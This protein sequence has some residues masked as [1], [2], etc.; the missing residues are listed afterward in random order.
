MQ[1]LLLLLFLAGSVVA[2][3]LPTSAPVFELPLLENIV[4]DGDGRDWADRGLAVDVLPSP[5]G[6]LAP[7]GDHN[8][9]LR[10]GWNDE[11][12]LLFAS[13]RDDAWVEH[14]D[15]NWLWRYDGIEVFLAS[16]PGS[17]N[18]CQWVI[19]PGMTP[20]QPNVRWK[21]HDHRKD[22]KARRQPAGL[23]L[24]R[25]KS[26]EGYG[27]E[28]LVPWK[29]LGIRP[30]LN[31]EAGLQI[32]VNDADEVDG[33]TAHA[34]WFPADNTVFETRNMH[35]IRLAS[36]AGPG[37][38]LLGHG[39]Y[40]WKQGEGRIVAT[41]SDRHTG[42]RVEVTRDDRVVASGRLKK[43]AGR[44]SAVFRVPVPFS[45]EWRERLRV[46][47]DGAVDAIPLREEEERMTNDV[48]KVTDG[49]LFASMELDRPGLGKVRAAVE[50]NDY[51]AAYREWGSY[52]ARRTSP[53]WYI[54]NESY[55]PGMKKKLPAISKIILEGCVPALE[56]RVAVGGVE[57]CYKDGTPDF[58][59]NPK[60]STNLITM[61]N[62]GFVEPLARAHL[63]TGEA[64]YARAY[65]LYTRALFEQR[66][67][68]PSFGLENMD[69][70]Y[71]WIELNTALRILHFVDAY[72]CMRQYEGLEAEDHEVALKLIYAC[73][74]L[75]ADGDRYNQHATTPN[76]RLVGMCALGTLG[77][78][79]PEFSNSDEW[80]IRGTVD[81]VRTLKDTVYADGA[82]AELCSQ[83]HMCAIRDPAKLSL[84]MSLNG[85]DGMYG[86]GEGA[87][88]F[89]S[90][91]AWMIN[92]VAPDGFI[93][94]LHSGVFCTEWL[95]YLLI[96]EHFNPG[97]FATT[98]E[99]YYDKGYVPV[100]K[101]GPGDTIILLTPDF[102]PS[103]P[104]KKR[105]AQEKGCYG[106][107]SWPSG[108]TS[109]QS[110]GDRDA[111]FLVTLNGKPIEGHG[112][113]QLGS[114]V[115]YSGGKWLALH[116]GSP[117]DY[118]H[119]EYVS[120]FHTTFSHNTV[121]V[122]GLNQVYRG[123]TN[124]A[125]NGEIGGQC[126]AWVETENACIMRTTHEGYKR[127][128]GILHTRTFFMLDEGWVFVHDYLRPAAEDKGAHV[129]DWALHT[130]VELK[131]GAG[132]MLTADSFAVVPAY[133]DEIREINFQVKPSMLPVRF[134]EGL[135]KQQGTAN[136]YYVRKGGHAATY[137]VALFPL[138]EGGEPPT[139]KALTPADRRHVAE[140]FE[141]S[142]PKGTTALLVRNSGKGDVGTEVDGV[143]VTSTA[144]AAAARLANGELTWI[145]EAGVFGR[146]SAL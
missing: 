104:G 36:K 71:C 108:L 100:A 88:V 75:L 15:P 5:L 67:S 122:D 114:F 90:L 60:E 42:E 145:V 47:M 7:P 129:F 82:H 89:R 49:E 31:M 123:S 61:W 128:N 30:A 53:V 86:E 136:Q 38:L 80:R 40:L 138:N 120:Y 26:A 44:A 29:S 103:L 39:K 113:P 146:G 52:M 21:L 141:I 105:P 124:M 96:Y 45:A 87:D 37:A 106:S 73:A 121:I 16:E 111:T 77:I 57:L 1:V 35:R 48:L 11:G 72:M 4:I 142:G 109:M 76:Q 19:S 3:P 137:G 135:H 93:P 125:W 58:S 50:K 143:T 83:Y 85:Y 59:R 22:V 63:I 74:E 33:D 115:L 110:G 8:S 65:Q 54:D 118:G 18:L 13:V 41:S 17:S 62:L 68:Q 94:P 84:V 66:N 99:Q 20:G 56:N 95:A 70:R 25:R 101:N 144:P 140:V 116:P 134:E 2:A 81:A 27:M 97:S 79:F 55:G 51:Q 117:F 10:L 98:I 12:L 34:A 107:N 119:K 28:V 92:A 102:L 23:R 43:E 14:E 139:V 46:R 130:P 6:E 9:S 69:Y 127:I 32:L 126:D 91:H 78:M 64:K 132:R 112:Y 133:P 24:A 131:E